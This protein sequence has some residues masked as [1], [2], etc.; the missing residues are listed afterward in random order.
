MKAMLYSD[1]M[2]N[3]GHIPSPYNY[4]TM[5]NTD[6]SLQETPLAVPAIPKTDFVSEPA[7]HPTPEPIVEKGS[8]TPEPEEPDDELDDL[9]DDLEDER[10]E[11]DKV[12]ESEEVQEIE[13][14][15]IDQDE[16]PENLEDQPPPRQS[17]RLRNTSSFMM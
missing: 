16:D 10:E 3:N 14:E 8:F 1:L 15:G 12:D 5:I 17:S 2:K 7:S 6:I 9:E 11:V 13:E 4:A